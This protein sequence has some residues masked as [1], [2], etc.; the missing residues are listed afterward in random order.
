MTFSRHCRSTLNGVCA[1]CGKAGAL[2][3]IMIFVTAAS[4][5]GQQ[6]VMLGC[7]CVSIVGMGITLSCVSEKVC[8]NSSQE[9]QKNEKR[10]PMK[11]VL[12]KPSLIDHFE[13]ALVSPVVSM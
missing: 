3:G 11:V 7:S 5:F 1:A 4:K 2:L 9:E 6:A 8:Q 12:S 13:T 10:I